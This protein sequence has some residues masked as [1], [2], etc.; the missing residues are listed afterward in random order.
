MD[1]ATLRKLYADTVDVPCSGHVYTLRQPDPPKAIA[2][3][4]RFLAEVRALPEEAEAREQYLTAMAEAIELT[5]E[6]D[7]ALPAGM[8]MRIVLG[9]G[10]VQSPVGTEAMRLC[11]LPVLR[12]GGEEAP[13]DLPT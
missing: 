5:L 11:G 3:L 4:T 7:G 2:V 8:A 12:R 6:V 9:T 10:S 13:A 1:I